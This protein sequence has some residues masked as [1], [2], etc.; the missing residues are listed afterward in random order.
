MNAT[1]L[2]RIARVDT[3]T[4][5]EKPARWI[6]FDSVDLIGYSMYLHEIQAIEVANV[7]SANDRA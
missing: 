7:S 2:R 5:E 1:G 3:V 6:F 4:S